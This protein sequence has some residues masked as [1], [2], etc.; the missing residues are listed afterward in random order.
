MHQ[1]S[2]KDPLFREYGQI[3]S[4]Y[5]F[6][7]LFEKL[8]DTPIPESGFLYQ[9]SD[10]TLEGLPIFLE[11]QDRAYGGLPMQL[12]YCNGMN[13][14]LNCLEY[15]RNSELI[16]TEF[17]TVLLLGHQK[18]I[19]ED[20]KY[21]TSTV[22][23]FLLSAHMGVE[24]FATTLHYAP[25]SLKGKRGFR[26]ANGLLRGTNG[27]RSERFVAKSSEDELLL[28]CN[29]WLLAHA[30]SEEAKKGAPVRLVGDNID[31]RDFGW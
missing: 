12:G 14:K 21:D 20:G 24:L 17:D 19:R 4:G 25:C 8:K 15:H 13:S 2:V 5:D 23:A 26:V 3:L 29:K 27:K 10:P 31:I 30:A 18:D 7:E 6:S 22:R 11:L 9:A 1:D 28:A 16:I